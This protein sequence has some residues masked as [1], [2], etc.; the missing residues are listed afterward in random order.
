MTGARQLAGHADVPEGNPVPFRARIR[1]ADKDPGILRIAG[2]LTP[3][4][5]ESLAMGARG[6]GAGARLE[7]TLG[8]NTSEHRLE[9][10]R[11]RFAGLGNRGIEV[12]VRRDGDRQRGVHGSAPA[13]RPR[14]QRGG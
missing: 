7:L 3:Y 10:V 14:G 5:L 13:A 9:W 8:A 2:F 1:T 11:R 12:S 4:E 6:M